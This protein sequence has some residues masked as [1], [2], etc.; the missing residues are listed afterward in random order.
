MEKQRE[1]TTKLHVDSY[2][3]K[4]HQREME[5]KAKMEKYSKPHIKR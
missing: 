1:D 5:M 4:T 2:V 3:H